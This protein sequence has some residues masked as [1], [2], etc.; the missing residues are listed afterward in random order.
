M[1]VEQSW[2]YMKSIIVKQYWS[3]LN[4]IGNYWSL[5]HNIGQYWTLFIDLNALKKITTQLSENSGQYL[6]IFFAILNDILD[7]I[8]ILQLYDI[9]NTI[10]Q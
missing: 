7:N 3:L 10:C 4:N 6:V 1:F 5:L 8:C 9:G 2:A